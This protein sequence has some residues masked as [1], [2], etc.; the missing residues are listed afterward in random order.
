[1]RK[2]SLR[3]LPKL[4]DKAEK[5]FHKWICLRDN[6]VCFTCD[7]TGNQG[8]HFKH[9]RLDFDEMNLNCQCSGCNHYRSGNLSV[10]AERLIDKYGVKKFKDLCFRANN[11][12]NKFSRDELEQIIV[13]YT[14]LVQSQY[15]RTKF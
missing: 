10:Y 2:H 11:Q 6:Y 5:I 9:N 8:G 12:S 13:K 1:M 3:T 4:K 14:S 15:D 7:K